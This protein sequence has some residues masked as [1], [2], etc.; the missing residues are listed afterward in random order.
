VIL[1]DAEVLQVPREDFLQMIY[2]DIQVTNHFIRI[3]AQNVKEKEERLLNLAY[4]SLRRRVAKALVEIHKKFNGANVED[5]IIEISRN[6]I[7]HYI[8]MT[9]ESVIRTLS[10]FKVERLI[11]IHEGKIRIINEEKLNYL[12]F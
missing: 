3:I 9:A 7:A 12:V 6:D 2:G 4:S 8:G 1:E 10:D 5:K 11:E